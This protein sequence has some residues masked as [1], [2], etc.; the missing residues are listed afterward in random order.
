M[1]IYKP[2]SCNINGKVLHPLREMPG[3]R[4]AKKNL[5]DVC[6]ETFKDMNKLNELIIL[7]KDNTNKILGS[8]RLV[9]GNN[10]P[11]AA[12]LYIQTSPEFRKKGYGIGELLRLTSIILILKNKIK[13][14]E[15][16]S[17]PEAIYF[18]S[19]YKFE[20]AIKNFEER[21]NALKNL[22]EK[23][24]TELIVFKTRANEILK[25]TSTIQDAEEQ[26]NLCRQT[27]KLLKEYIQNILQTKNK[28]KAYPF[29]SGIRMILKTEEIFRNKDF[30]NELFKKHCID[31]KI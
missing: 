8:E 31:Y 6:I 29:N 7:L 22:I 2:N 23:C 10:N 24:D 20:P 28:Y 25:K 11:N 3:I 9:M 12:G 30:F 21:D 1:I 27:N 19:K 17:K 26:R 13:E 5:G 18:H 16:Y 15:I 14:F 4:I